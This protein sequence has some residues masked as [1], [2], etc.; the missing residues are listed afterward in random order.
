M[1][2]TDFPN[3]L[4]NFYI[5]FQGSRKLDPRCTNTRA[6]DATFT[7]D[8]GI[9]TTFD[10]NVPRLT[11]TGLLLEGN[12][13]NFCTDSV[14]MSNFLGVRNTTIALDATEV[15]PDG[16]TGTVQLLS[17]VGAAGT[18]VDFG[19]VRKQLTGL[20]NTEFCTSVYAKADG[21]QWLALLDMG[22]AQF[23]AYYDVQNGV[24]GTV[25]AGWQA[26]IE[27]LGN[28][29]FRCSLGQPDEDFQQFA[30]GLADA[31]N[32]PAITPGGGILVWG[33]Q[34]EQNTAM[35][36][37]IP[38]P[39]TTTATRAQDVMQIANDDFTSWWNDPAGTMIVSSNNREFQTTESSKLLEAFTTSTILV[40]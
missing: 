31:D 17:Y 37:Y 26:T 35:T 15:A 18:T 20:A 32:D 13:T 9:L 39:P 28:G 21:K 16:T 40:I 27:T 14:G 23:R 22:S 24:L 5:G 29:W 2:V 8:N 4:P 1:T 33:P 11:N 19:I 12:G 3:A 7:A 6:S 25:Q 10:D 36:S 34:C 38:T 30:I